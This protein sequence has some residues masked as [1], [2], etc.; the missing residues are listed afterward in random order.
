M[1]SSCSPGEG[2]PGPG[3][4]SFLL[5][6][7]LG[8]AAAAAT[9]SAD[10]AL[11]VTHVNVVDVIHGKVLRDRTVEVRGG[12]IARL[13]RARSSESFPKETTVLDATG[14]YLIPGL[15]DMHAHLRDPDREMALLIANGVLGVRDMGAVPEKIYAWRD[16]VAKGERLG[17]HIIACGPIVDGPEPSNPP[18]S[19]V[20][21]D[22]ASGRAIVTALLLA[23]SQCVKV[24]DRVPIDAYRAIAAEADRTGLPLVGHVPLAVTTLEATNAGQR[25]LEHQVGLRGCSSAEVEVMQEEAT[26]NVMAEAMSSGDFSLIPESIARRGNRILDGLDPIRCRNLYR[27]FARNGT[28]LDPTLVTQVGLTFVDDL[29]RREDPRMKYIPASE[30]EYWKPEKGMLTRYRTPAYIAYRKREYA[31]TLEHIP[32]AHAAGVSFLAGTDMWLPYVYPGFSTHDEM[33]LFVEAGLSPIEALRTATINPAKLLGL[34]ART[35]SVEEG[36]GAD[37]VLLDA[38]PLQDIS[39]TSRISAVVVAG[40]LLRRA[41]L[42]RLLRDAEEAARSA[43]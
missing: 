13:R 40:R 37:L 38:N 5:A 3:P 1:P 19:V 39:H 31:A 16:Q 23:G 24:H 7:L 18:I 29:A 21:S 8:L 15:W 10:P 27:A 33:R 28:Y 12:R 11:V 17:P 32:M 25:S 20:A 43:P 30:R 35:G 4:G 22:A 42:D 34:S 41:D 9:P 6:A 2:P 14:K 36:K 26:S